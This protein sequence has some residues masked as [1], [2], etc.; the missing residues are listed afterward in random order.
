VGAVAVGLAA[1][2]L[3]VGV[4]VVDAAVPPNV[5][6]LPLEKR[7]WAR[8][9]MPQGWAF[10]TR[11]PREERLLLFMKVGGTEWVSL[12]RGPYFGMSSQLG[13]SRVARARGIEAGLLQSTLKAHV[14]QECRDD[15]HTC[16][17]RF[18][19]PVVLDNPSPVPLLCGEIALAL[20]KPVPWAW[21]RDFRG[22]MPSKVV[23]LRV[24][25]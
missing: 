7:I 19:P 8:V 4:Y 16:L 11:N 3:L 14:W 5:V 12:R 2:W 20:R 6:R 18:G 9:W 24:R 1:C 25:C 21:T 22:N 13:F 17:D 23:K 10:F 15:V